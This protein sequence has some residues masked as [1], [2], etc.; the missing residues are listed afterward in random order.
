MFNPLTPTEIVSAIGKTARAA[1]TSEEQGSDFDRDQLMSA[2]SATR[3][4]AVEMKS[5][6]DPLGK[7]ATGLA[8]LIEADSP[9]LPAVKL[10]VLA[11]RPRECITGEEVGDAV[12]ILVESLVAAGE[13]GAALLAD[14]HRRLRDLADLEVELLADGLT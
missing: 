4:L 10:A 6:A 2:Y 5:F 7:F 8:D 14:V 12:A 9:P 1:A 3:H 13:P 11:D